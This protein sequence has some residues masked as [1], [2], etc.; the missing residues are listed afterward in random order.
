MNTSNV[1]KELER[2][3]EQSEVTAHM[4]LLFSRHPELC[5]FVVERNGDIAEISL[6]PPPVSGEY[7]DVSEDIDE[8]VSGIL[9]ER[10]E[11]YEHLVR[12]RAFARTL[13]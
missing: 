6:F 2:I 13:H 11:V 12:G 5:G 8:I 4:R 10:P 9:A 7:Y 1:T 3:R